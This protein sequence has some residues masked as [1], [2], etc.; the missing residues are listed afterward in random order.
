M[1]YETD[2]VDAGLPFMASGV[3]ISTTSK[4]INDN[5]VVNDEFAAGEQNARWFKAVFDSLNPTPSARCAFTSP[6]GG[7]TSGSR[8]RRWI[9]ASSSPTS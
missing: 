6:R 2:F 3:A 5:W 4:L 9:R 7:T 8:T 1:D